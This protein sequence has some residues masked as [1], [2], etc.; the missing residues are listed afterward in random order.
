MQQ[1]FRCASVVSSSAQCCFFTSSLN[2]ILSMRSLHHDLR[3]C[4]PQLPNQRAVFRAVAL[5][6]GSSS[7]FCHDRLA[8]LE[9]ETLSDSEVFFVI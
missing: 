5:L 2:N 9:M 7:V 1:A 4:L 8:P 6:R 3:S